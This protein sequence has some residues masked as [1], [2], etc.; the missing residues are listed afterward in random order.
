MMGDREIGD[1]MVEE[2]PNFIED[3][4]ALLNGKM[5]LSQYKKA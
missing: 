1:F 5:T 4:A 2:E 3:A